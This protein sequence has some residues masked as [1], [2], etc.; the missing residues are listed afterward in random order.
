[1]PVLSLHANYYRGKSQVKVGAF[2]KSTNIDIS[3]ILCG[4]WDI[5][6]ELVDVFTPAEP[7]K[8]PVLSSSSCNSNNNSNSLKS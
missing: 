3:S 8:D 4:S 1:M 5:S 7:F 6:L 2:Q